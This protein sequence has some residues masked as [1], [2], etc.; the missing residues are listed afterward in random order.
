LSTRCADISPAAPNPENEFSSCGGA[1][2][3]LPTSRHS[4]DKY[5][6]NVLVVLIFL[7]LEKAP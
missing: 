4:A 6:R 7:F 5:T 1:M 2:D 3:A